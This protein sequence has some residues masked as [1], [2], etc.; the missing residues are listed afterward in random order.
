M[1]LWFELF[2]LLDLCIPHTLWLL[3]V[4]Q[5]LHSNTQCQIF[6][7]DIRNKKKKR[8][9]L[10]REEKLILLFTIIVKLNL[11]GMANSC[12]V[13]LEWGGDWK[14]RRVP[15]SCPTN[16]FY[17]FESLNLLHQCLC[18]CRMVIFLIT[19]Y[20]R[21]PGC[22]DDEWDHLNALGGS[23]LCPPRET[24]PIRNIWLAFPVGLKPES[25]LLHVGK[26]GSLSREPHIYCFPSLVCSQVQDKVVAPS[27]MP[28]RIATCK[29][30]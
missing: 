9:S 28:W 16:I 19:T 23:E 4:I 7:Q 22:Y 10:Q 12:F 29:G 26:V 17:K 11:Y 3:K 27:G 6:F 2:S 30:P 13:F 1:A 20:L 21:P 18:P 25:L 5:L 14:Y 24:D 15:L 8:W